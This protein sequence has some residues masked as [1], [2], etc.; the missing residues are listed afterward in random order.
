MSKQELLKTETFY[1]SGEQEF[2]NESP[3]ASL[4]S[5]GRLLTYNEQLK[6]SLD[7][8]IN[9]TQ[10]LDVLIKTKDANELLQAATK[11]VNYQLDTAYL[12]Y[13]QK[14]SL[15]DFYLIF[16]NRLLELHQNEKVSLMSSEINNE[17]YHEYP[18]LQS[19]G[20]FTFTQVKEHS[21]GA[22]YTDKTTQEKIFY[23]DFEKKVLAFNS[24][25]LTNLFVVEYSRSFE[26]AQLKEVT[27]L[28]LALGRY[29]KEDYGFDVDFNLLDP[30]NNAFYEITQTSL[31][32]EA[33]DKLFVQAAKAGFMLVN[34]NDNEA[35]LNLDG[36]TLSLYRQNKEDV[37]EK[38]G[39]NVSDPNQTISW[40]DVLF[41]Y[42]F[43]REWYLE[44]LGSLEIISDPR[45]F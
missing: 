22:Y 40:F 1:P 15:S 35:I 17:L 4:S 29:L 10:I 27:L 20:Y 45:Y 24:Q 43:L 16:I 5:T 3:Q 9:F 33:L 2:V 7:N 8:G 42:E 14:Y 23:L 19:K 34:G 6:A 18:T 39:I 44:N 38:W 37:V 31:P 13:L 11:L 36:V 28:L 26:Y 12:V 30:A 41:K 21:T 32:Q 25:A